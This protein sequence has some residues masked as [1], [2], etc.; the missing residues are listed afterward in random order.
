MPAAISDDRPVR[1]GVL[2]AGSIAGTVCSDLRLTSGNVVTAVAARDAD[3]AAAFA[4]E[5]GAA[6]SYGSYEDLVT[7]DEVDVVYVATTHP[8]H[9]RQALLA[10][11]AGKSVLVEKPV[12]LHA[13]QAREVF[14]AA[15]AADVFAMEAMWTRANPLVRKAQQLA[16]DG[17]IGEVR[18]VRAS[19]GIGVPFDPTSRL[20]DLANGGGA[21]LDLGVYPITIA[22]LFVGL[23]DRAT[24][25]GTLSPTGSDET[26]AVQWTAA[27]R[28]TAQLMFSAAV[29]MSNDTVIG[30]TEGFLRLESP[31]HRPSGLTVS[32][33][34]EERRIEDPLAGHG[35]GYT[36]QVE[37]VER[38]LRAGLLESPLVPHA[39]TVAIQELMDEGLAALGVVYPQDR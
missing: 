31:G 14:D 12:C 5:H 17:T 15:R 29:V 37:E 10:I 21:L 39:D 7:D 33:G 32:V 2:G 20:Y 9:H 13:A 26:V 27:G 38:C 22:S 23:P 16:A 4:A 30:G 8:N 34:G 6:R 36:P 3:R 24:W 25:S 1:W 28:P 19:F 18:H 11:E 35:A